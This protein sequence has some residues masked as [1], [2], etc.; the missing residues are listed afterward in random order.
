MTELDS[1]ADACISA[2]DDFVYREL[3]KTPDNFAAFKASC[4]DLLSK[5]GNNLDSQTAAFR[6]FMGF[7]PRTCDAMLGFY[8]KTGIS[9]SSIDK[10]QV[11]KDVLL[12][13]NDAILTSDAVA[14]ADSCRSYFGRNKPSSKRVNI[15]RTFAR[16]RS[17]ENL[18]ESIM[19]VI[20]GQRHKVGT[21]QMEFAVTMINTTLEDR[22]R[23]LIRNRLSIILRASLNGW[24]IES[25]P[26][27]H[28]MQFD[29]VW[30]SK[31]VEG[32]NNRFPTFG[33]V[34]S[35]KTVWVSEEYVKLMI[36]SNETEKVTTNL[37][38]VINNVK[39]TDVPTRKRAR[40]VMSSSV[41]VAT[42]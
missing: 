7:D 40:D 23:T 32:S 4:M 35:K 3:H 16:I 28:D 42:V 6:M 18:M 31:F 22:A 39:K 26:F 9:T 2:F 33:Y 29:A 34:L 38:T 17:K 10:T 30:K 25:L 41:E 19:E 12:S 24:V 20:D 14:F 36:R 37:N 21:I 15:I 27:L 1:A 8:D 11:I 13:C 5:L